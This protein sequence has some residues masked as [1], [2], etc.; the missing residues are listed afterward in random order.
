M[1]IFFNRTFAEW[2]HCQCKS[3]YIVLRAYLNIERCQYT[4]YRSPKGTKFTATQ[5]SAIFRI[6]TDI[7]CNP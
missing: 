6:H 7:L 2:P 1:F 3:V 4:M 5:I